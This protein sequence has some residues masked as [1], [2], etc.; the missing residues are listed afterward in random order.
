MMK[1]THDMLYGNVNYRKESVELTRSYFWCSVIV[2]HKFLSHQCYLY[3]SLDA[4]G[5]DKTHVDALDTSVMS[6][7]S[8]VQDPES[9]RSR[10]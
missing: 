9:A 1:T 3:E 6:F 10:Y 8:N 7:Q 5:M 2:L 4:G